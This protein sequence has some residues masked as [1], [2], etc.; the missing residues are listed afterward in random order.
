MTPL[1][2]MAIDAVAEFPPTGPNPYD[3]LHAV[4]ALRVA[5]REMNGDWSF[6]LRDAVE[7]TGWAMTYR[8]PVWP[9]RARKEAALVALTGRLA[10][11]A[12]NYVHACNE[13]FPEGQNDP[14]YF[15]RQTSRLRKAIIRVAMLPTVD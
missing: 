1:Q 6:G 5:A 11:A 15:T 14:D 3:R 12:E 10:G 7:L 13:A 8:R 9:T 2:R 4:K